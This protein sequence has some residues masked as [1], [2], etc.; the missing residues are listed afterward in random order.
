MG[1]FSALSAGIARADVRHVRLDTDDAGRL[2]TNSRRAQEQMVE[3]LLEQ[4]INVGR[5][6]QSLHSASTLILY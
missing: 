4:L 1:A 3:Q 5:S 6:S 2:M